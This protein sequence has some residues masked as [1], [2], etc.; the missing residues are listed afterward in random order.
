M[1]IGPAENGGRPIGPNEERRRGNESGPIPAEN[2]N[3]TD[4]IE[5]SR[6]G[7]KL[8]EKKNAA[9]TAD[10][11]ARHDTPAPADLPKLLSAFPGDD[12]DTEIRA[13]KVELAKER[14]ASGHYDSPQVKNEIARRITG[15]FIG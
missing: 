11:Q 6:Y 12:P 1:K 3:K 4:K 7:R 8:A 14:L 2:L 5:I 15:D 10:T 13:D 9:E